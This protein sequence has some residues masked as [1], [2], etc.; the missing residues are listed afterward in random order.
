MKN[1]SSPF[2]SWQGQIFRLESKNYSLWWLLDSLE[3]RVEEVEDQIKANTLC[4]QVLRAQ[5][6]PPE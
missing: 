5:K 6:K 1:S 4:L 2:E 3:D